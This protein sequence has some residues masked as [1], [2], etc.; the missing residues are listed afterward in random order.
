MIVDVSLCTPVTKNHRG[1]LGFDVT[2]EGDR[3]R[4]EQE[5]ERKRKRNVKGRAREKERR[6][7]T[8]RVSHVLLGANVV[9]RVLTYTSVRRV[10]D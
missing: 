9:H 4:E 2:N 10:Q 6:G 5:R 3:E 7:C 8:L 1:L